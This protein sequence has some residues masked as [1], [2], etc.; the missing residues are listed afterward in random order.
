MMAI[1][2]LSQDVYNLISKVAVADLTGSVALIL[3]FLSDVILLQCAR[4]QKRRATSLSIRT[5]ASCT[6]ALSP[7]ITEWKRELMLTQR[8]YG[9]RPVS[10]TLLCY[11]GR[12]PQSARA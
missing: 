7:H 3:P 1:V 10:T 9:E 11:R 8:F 12:G 5:T 6:L 2:Y 4:D